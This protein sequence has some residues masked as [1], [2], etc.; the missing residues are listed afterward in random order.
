MTAAGFSFTGPAG[1]IPITG[2]QQLS[3]TKFRVNFAQQGVVGTYTMTVS[4]V[5]KN[6]LGSHLDQNNN[7]TGNESA[8]QY[9]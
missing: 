3:D 7:G 8:D 6:T 9:F 1:N 4:P 2:V 5:I